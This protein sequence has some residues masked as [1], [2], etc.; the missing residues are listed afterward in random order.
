MSRTYSLLV[1][2]R[3][4][5]VK[6]DRAVRLGLSSVTTGLLPTVS[7]FS[8]LTLPPNRGFS[9]LCNFRSSNYKGRKDTSLKFEAT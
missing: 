3:P 4:H 8:L 5:F 2:E 1:A 6:V 7:R 9:H